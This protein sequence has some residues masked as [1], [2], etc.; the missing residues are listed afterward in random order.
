M[1]RAVHRFETRFER[2]E[3]KYLI[4]EPLAVRLRA[5]LDPYCRLDE[6]AAFDAGGIAPHVPAYRV[7][8]LYLDTPSLEF[9]R[10]KERGDAERIKLRVRRYA[11]MDALALEIKRRRAD[12]GE[13]LR[14][15]VASDELEA[16][17]RGFAK[18]L[19]ESPGARRICDEFA[20]LV[21]QS[22]AEPKLLVRYM[23]EA[24]ASEV[25]GYA[26]VTLDR[27]IAAQRTERWSF[28]AHAD[29]WCA[30][31]DYQAPGSPR[32]AVVLELKCESR[33]PAWMTELVRR[34]ALT[35][36][37]FSKYSVGIAMTG[38]RAGSAELV[39]RIGGVVR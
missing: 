10:A 26:R 11:G 17:A 24:H 22:G 13:K 5:D 28:D 37:S 9:Y 35:R 1:P 19:D 12:C 36:Q 27:R 30:L 34:H 4:A 20:R 38:R 23:R 6:N 25:D 14:V 16:A 29:E 39:R 7:D 31:E 2:L 15:L 32:P 8:T 33:V 21:L 3:L 18:P